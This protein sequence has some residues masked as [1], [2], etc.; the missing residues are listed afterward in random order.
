MMR[1]RWTCSATATDT[2]GKGLY[3][4]GPKMSVRH[5]WAGYPDRHALLFFFT[6][7]PDYVTVKER[8]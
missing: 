5:N 1:K 7:D 8:G 6:Q 2:T 3:V 4:A